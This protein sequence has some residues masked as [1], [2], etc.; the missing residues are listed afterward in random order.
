MGLMSISKIRWALFCDDDD[1]DEDDGCDEYEYDDYDDD[2]SSDDD[3][4]D[5]D[6]NNIN[7]NNNDLQILCLS[8]EKQFLWTHVVW[9]MSILWS[10]Y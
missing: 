4:S 6:E 8:M 10:N 3:S 9:D 7:N 5:D 2:D 1:Y